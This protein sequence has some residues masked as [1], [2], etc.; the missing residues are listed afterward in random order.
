MRF[1]V[2][3]PNCRHLAI[4]DVIRGTAARAEALTSSSS[5]S[6]PTSASWPRR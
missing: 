5:S 4:P 2:W 3:L 1:G 6:A